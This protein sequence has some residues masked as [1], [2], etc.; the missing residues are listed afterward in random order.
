MHKSYCG[1]AGGRFLCLDKLPQQWWPDGRH[2][3]CAK[4]IDHIYWFAVG[5]YTALLSPCVVDMPPDVPADSIVR[6]I[7][8]QK[9]LF[10]LF[11]CAAAFGWLM[12][13]LCGRTK[14]KSMWVIATVAGSPAGRW[15][16]IY[17]ALAIQA[18]GLT[19]GFLLHLSF[20]ITLNEVLFA[21]EGTI[22]LLALTPVVVTV[23][24]ERCQD[25]APSATIM[26]TG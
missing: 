20:S 4:L 13:A 9:V 15:S 1:K 18:V 26:P 6:L 24:E 17:P 7:W 11:F 21:N 10:V 19:A 25:P 8:S 5:M 16:L 22:I 3:M 12:R 2:E 14:C 23:P